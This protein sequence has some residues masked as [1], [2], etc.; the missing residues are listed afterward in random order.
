MEGLPQRHDLKLPDLDAG[1]Q[2]RMWQSYRNSRKGLDTTSWLPLTLLIPR[3]LIRGRAPGQ[4]VEY[5][6]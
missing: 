5:V 4:G 6:S 1:Q 3:R 2:Q